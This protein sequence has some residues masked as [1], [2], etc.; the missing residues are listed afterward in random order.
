MLQERKYPIFATVR[1]DHHPVHA[2]LITSTGGD[3]MPEES[4]ERRRSGVP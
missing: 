2:L 3:E 1:I 4:V